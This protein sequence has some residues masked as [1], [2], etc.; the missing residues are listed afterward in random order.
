MKEA[1]VVI[2]VEWCSVRGMQAISED[3]GERFGDDGLAQS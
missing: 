2:V 1:G 3:V